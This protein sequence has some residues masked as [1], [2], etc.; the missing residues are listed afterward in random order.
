MVLERT[1]YPRQYGHADQSS[2]SWGGQFEWFWGVPETLRAAATENSRRAI[3]AAPRHGDPHPQS[4]GYW[5]ALQILLLRRLGW[6]RPDLGLAWWYDEGKPTDDPT[7]KLISDAWDADGN[8]DIYLGWLLLR[9][10]R[11]PVGTPNQSW[12]TS[13]T[14]GRPLP[15]R[16]QQWLRQLETSAQATEH[17]WF[18]LDPGDSLHLTGHL[19][20]GGEPDLAAY[21]ATV[22]AEHRKAVFV[23]SAADTWY[24]DLK[25]RGDKLPVAG[26]QSWK[27]DV[28]VKPIGYLGTYRKSM[29]TGLWFTGRHRYHAAGN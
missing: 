23:T 29:Q 3:P 5:A 25:N 19:G 16:W 24:V 15:Q 4:R 18:T 2:I 22:A 11:F 7:L 12:V 28:F 10:N 13:T 14:S 9:R 8:L 27:V 6:T 17:Q 20:E 26:V 21:L 1:V